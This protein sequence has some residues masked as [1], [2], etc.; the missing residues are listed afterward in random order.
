MNPQ[1]GLEE[2]DL[3]QIVVLSELRTRPRP[4]KIPTPSQVVEYSGNLYKV[5]AYPDSVAAQESRE[6]IS[7][8]NHLFIRCYGQIDRFLVLE[9]IKGNKLDSRQQVLVDIADFLENLSTV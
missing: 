7:A 4:P 3:E 2:R 8:V 9:Y 5:R 1:S 6:L